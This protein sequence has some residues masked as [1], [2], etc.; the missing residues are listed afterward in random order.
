MAAK[1]DKKNKDRKGE[2]RRIELSS[3]DKKHMAALNWLIY[4]CY[5]KGS[6]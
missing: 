3:V 5:F 6:V 2:K 4:G 1:E